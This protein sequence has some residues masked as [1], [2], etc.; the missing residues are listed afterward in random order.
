[1]TGSDNRR[2]RA[3]RRRTGMRLCAIGLLAL[4]MTNARAEIAYTA[5]DIGASVGAYSSNAIAINGEGQI[6]GW[7]QT[8][9]RGPARAFITGP[10]GV[11]FTDLGTPGGMSDRI[12]GIND[13]GQVTGSRTDPGGGTTALISG[14]GG[15]G[16][17]LLDGATTLSW[18]AAINA[19]GQVVGAVRPAGQ[20]D[21]SPFLTGPN[22]SSMALLGNLGADTAFAKGLN[23][24]GQV[25]GVYGN[26]PGGQLRAFIT[27]AGGAN[28][29]DLGSL[30]GLDTHA[31]GINATGR[32]VGFTGTALL[33]TSP[34]GRIVAGHAFVTGANG[35]GMVDL[36]TLGGDSSWG[37]DINDSGVVVGY[38]TI[39]GN[40]NPHAM[41]FGRNGEGMQD[42]N[43]LAQLPSGV[44]LFDATAINNA[45]QILAHG[46]NGQVWL[47]TPVPEPHEYAQLLAGLLLV[48]SIVWSRGKKF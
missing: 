8:V 12:L 3:V 24:A 15:V 33:E 37:G 22:G 13:T 10:Q 5:L 47:L 34:G 1:M 42:L 20:S 32:V 6:A 19:G 36:G 28:Q 43:S 7:F 23:D 25:V 48:G 17:T 14:P 46:T 38:S 18:G 9:A 41:V 39:V 11:G 30:Y 2:D 26:L 21:T 44:T 4:L 16:L 45:G 29:R 35:T 40:T 27:D 31:N